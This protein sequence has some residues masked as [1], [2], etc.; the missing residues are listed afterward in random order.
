[1]MNSQF[2]NKSLIQREIPID[3]IGLSVRPYIILKHHKSKMAGKVFRC[4]VSHCINVTSC[5]MIAEQV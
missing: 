1:M 5:K 4:L 2:S 3:F